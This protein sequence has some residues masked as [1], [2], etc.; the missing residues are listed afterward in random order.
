MK[1]CSPR[2]LSFH[3]HSMDSVVLGM[4]VEPESEE[5]VLEQIE[6][7]APSAQKLSVCAYG[8]SVYGKPGAYAGQDILV[9]CEDYPNGLRAHRRIA[10]GLETR[11]LVAER[12]L[13]ESDVRKGTLGD[14]LTEILLY[15]SRPIV[16]PVY[17][18]N[19]AVD[20]KARTIEEETRDLI[21]EYGEMC[22]G[23][24]AEPEF[25]GLS[26]LRKRARV[27]VPSMDQYLRLLERSVRQRN[28]EALRDS[29]KKVILSLKNDI[30]ELEDDHVAIPDSIVDKWL[31]RRSSEQVVNILRQS[32]QTFYSYLTRGRVIYADLDLLAREVYRPLRVGLEMEVM[33]AQPEDPK[34]YLYLRTAEGL[35]SLNERASLEDI[36]SKL[37]P[38]RTITIAPLAGVLNEVFL[39]TTGNES[40][41]AK[42]F[43]DWHGFKWFTLNLVSFGSK[44]FAV[45][46]KARMSNEYGVN[47]Y[48]AK[49]AI[50][51][52]QIIHVNMKERILLESYISGT[53]IVQTLIQT[54]T[55]TT[56]SESQY[57]LAESLGETLA[58]I[59]AV[60]VSVGDSKPENFVAHDRDV[61]VVD[62]EQGGKR[63]DFAWDIAELLFYAGHYS[64][65]PVPPHGLIEAVHAFIQGYARR[66]DPSELRRAA[67]VKYVKVFSLWTHTPIILEI[68]KMLRENH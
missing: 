17:L 9:I 34:N 3:F 42:K 31:A 61:Y 59:H 6:E 48:L 55:Q 25:F 65:S 67:G 52:P 4:P 29:F 14:F 23:F 26:R 47:R 7:L 13:I 10:D 44:F 24:V 63:K 16:N 28:I 54:M 36:I 1:F 49:R 35:A 51:V 32:R 39:V 60:G 12:S 5:S 40:Y 66:G 45:S 37:R 43:T 2:P 58:R 8:P 41:V 30:V 11:F 50:K 20:A 19:L 57:K 33:G 18:E 46:G 62:L 64:V 38:G 27:F 21:I 56:L 22:R 53:P 15:P 68:S